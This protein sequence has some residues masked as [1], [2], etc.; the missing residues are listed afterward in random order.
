MSVAIALIWPIIIIIDIGLDMNQHRL[1]HPNEV[2]DAS[3]F[4]ILALYFLGS[5]SFLAWSC[6][7]ARGSIMVRRKRTDR[8]A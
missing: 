7:G 5:R 2:D 6:V 3:G 8:P 1:Q 4:I